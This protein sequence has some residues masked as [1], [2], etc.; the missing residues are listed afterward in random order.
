VG[1][2]TKKMQRIGMMR[3]GEENLPVKPFRFSQATRLM[4]PQGIGEHLLNA[5]RRFFGHEFPWPAARQG[6][7]IPGM[8]E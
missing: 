1:K 2:N 8:L 7:F 3:I 5:R 6:I 4:M